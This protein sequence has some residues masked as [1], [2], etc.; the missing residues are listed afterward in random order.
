MAEHVRMDVI[1]DLGA[2][3]RALGAVFWVLQTVV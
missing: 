2:V 1:R 3:N